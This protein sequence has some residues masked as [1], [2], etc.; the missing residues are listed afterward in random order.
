MLRRTF[1]R[2]VDAQLGDVNRWRFRQFVHLAWHLRRTRPRRRSCNICAFDGFFDPAGWPLRP[3]AQC[4][5][6]SSLERHRLF[7]LWFDAHEQRLVGSKLLHFAPE[8]SITRFVRP[9]VE[10]YVTA[11][12]AP[13]RADL[14]LNIEQ[15]DQPDASFDAI[16]CFH[17]LEH[18]EDRKA[19]SELRRILRPN[20]VLLL[21]FPI[22]EGWSATY[23]NPEITSPDDRLLH[24][25]QADHVR[26]FGSDVR[27]RI[28]AAGFGLSE[29]TADNPDQIIRYGLMRG[30]KLFVA[31]PD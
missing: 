15:I 30:E 1:A 10:T 17:I 8:P 13:G 2:A 5:R 27:D 4:P 29:F 14:V 11:D 18:V 26:F 23:E 22:V 6:C 20:G 19:L 21:M 31:T 24:F 25:G 7:K 9:S 28:R 3:D 16:L 12:V